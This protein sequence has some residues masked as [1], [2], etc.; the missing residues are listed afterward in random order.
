VTDDAGLRHVMVFA[1][2]D[3]VGF[4]DATGLRSVPFAADAWLSP[5]LTTLTIIATDADGHVTATSRGVYLSDDAL[6]AERR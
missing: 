5:G 1:G 3:K 2:D 4:E 6:R